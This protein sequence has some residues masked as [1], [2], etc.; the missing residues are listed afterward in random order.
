MTFGFIKN[1]CPLPPSSSTMSQPKRLGD[2]YNIRILV[3][4]KQISYN[5]KSLSNKKN[6][7]IDVI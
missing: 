7:V 1:F 3:D 4:M 5:L 2:E 6:I